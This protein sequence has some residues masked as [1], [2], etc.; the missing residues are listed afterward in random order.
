MKCKVINTNKNL[1]EDEINIWLNSGKYEIYNFAQT[2]T[3][4]NYITVTIL[5]YDNQEIRKKKLNNLKK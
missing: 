1:L 4:D 3:S 2:Q 5:Y